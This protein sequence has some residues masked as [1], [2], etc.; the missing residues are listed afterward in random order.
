MKI[1][2][3]GLAS[4]QV[5]QLLQHHLVDMAKH[6]PPE[7]VHA[8]DI[9]ALR[10]PEVT[11]ISLWDGDNVAGVAAIKELDTGNGEIKSMRTAPAYLRRGVAGRLLDKLIKV[12]RERGYHSLWL[13]TGSADAFKPARLFYERAGFALC[14]PFA[15]Y[16]HDPHSV[17]M[18]KHLPDN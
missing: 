2:E 9:D 14:E 13:E 5:Q 6:S 18:M 3:G 7:S 16:T 11:F 15:D 17:F 10:V 8:L 12:A 4:E 1:I